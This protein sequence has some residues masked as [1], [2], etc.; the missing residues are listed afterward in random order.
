M[1]QPDAGLVINVRGG[2][3]LHVPEA[4]SQYTTYVLLEQEDWFEDEI[5]FVR[6]WLRPGMRAVDVGASY[7]IYTT[8]MSRAVGAGGRVWAFEPTP[9][10][11]DFLQRN[12]HFNLC[13]NVVLHRYAVSDRDGELP[14]AIDVHSEVNAIAGAGGR[15]DIRVKAVTLD[16]AAAADNWGEIDFHKL[17]VE[18]HEL[19]AIRG[20][21][22][23][24]A[25]HSPLVML[26]IK[27]GD[28]VDLR[29]LGPLRELGYSIYRLLPERLILV[30]FDDMDAA[31]PF[32]LNVFAC[33]S[34][35]A[36]KLAAQ[37]V[38]ALD[39]A[40][41]AASP[42]RGAWA[43]YLRSVPYAR[44]FEER[45]AANAALLSGADART[46]DEGLASYA[47]SREQGFSPTQQFAWLAHAYQCVAEALD[48]RATL[49]RRVSYARLAW[50][51]GLRGEAV[52]ALYEA[53]QSLA[54][55][56]AGAFDEPFLA[57]CVRFEQLDSRVRPSDWL[58]CALIEQFERLRGYTSFS[59]AATPA[60]VESIVDL[61]YR[62]AEMERRRQLVR[63]RA[64]QQQAPERAPLLSE[65]SDGNLN[66]EFW[67]AADPL[68]LGRPAG[69]SRAF[70][71]L[72]VVAE[73]PRLKI[74]DIG[75][76]SR[77]EDSDPYAPLLRALNC[78]VVGFE[79]LEDECEKLNRAAGENRSYLPLVIGD[80]S[81]QTFYECSA[82]MTSSLFEPDTALLDMFQNLEE[83]VRVV[84]TRRV[85]TRRLDD[86]PQAR[87]VDFLKVDVQGAELMVFQ[88]AQETLRDV[89][90]IQ[91]EAEFVPLYKG[92]PLFADVDAFLRSQGF[93]LHKLPFLAG[94]TFKPL[95]LVENPYAAISQ[96][97]W[98]DAVYVRD[99]M[100]FHR[101]APGRLLK[102]A[103]ILHENYAS[104]DLAAVALQAYDRQT[105][106]DLQQRYLQRMVKSPA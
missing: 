13:S 8:A 28:R 27:V 49:S 81:E 77:G 103:A 45:W 18:G 19:E 91:T 47:H 78:E 90:V 98:C 92:Q 82:P 80:G 89:L 105:G 29:A 70:S 6:Y 24:L 86:I 31:E 2:V 34:D 12:L 17:D 65:R 35:R 74:V 48:A 56:G 53:A 33:K 39:D 3:R 50:E 94:R 54:D 37:G 1:T 5:R 104:H 16:R 61:P 106:G 68:Q 22:G 88:G 75:A 58:K 26:E 25:A 76:M 32:R 21:T 93:V 9:E 44:G 15:D 59:H 41:S 38:L 36:G 62:S 100:A 7:G 83:L 73:L 101:L 51:L 63:M 96:I 42:P 79:P 40:A 4:L 10:T 57:P 43:N 97:L 99:F 14:F 72:A 67:C 46:Y 95:M 60:V 11:A 20:G 85:Q 84:A 55:E 30:P 66:P 23:F 71:I 87:G 69:A 52:D 102:L 64:G